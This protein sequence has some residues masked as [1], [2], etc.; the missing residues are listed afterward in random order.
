MRP[1]LSAGDATATFGIVVSYI[2]GKLVEYKDESP[3]EVVWLERW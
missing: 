1:D 3:S 2:H